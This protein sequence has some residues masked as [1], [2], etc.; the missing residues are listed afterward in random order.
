MGV[1]DQ[2]LVYNRWKTLLY[3][4]SPFICLNCVCLLQVLHFNP[5]VTPQSTQTIWITFGLQVKSLAWLYT[6]ASW[7]IYT[8]PA[9]SIST[10]WVMHRQTCWHI[11][12]H[13][14]HGYISTWWF[15]YAQNDSLVGLSVQVSQ[16]IIRTYLPLI[17]NM[18]RTCSGFWT[19]TSV[20][21][22]LS[23]PFL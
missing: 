12:I 6:I 14:I 13:K 15:T 1:T 23:S 8:S 3:K 19:M 2:R 9:P 16:W 5:T 11:N 18:P 4:Y 17:Q 21:W 20:T 7:W 22:A 10:Y